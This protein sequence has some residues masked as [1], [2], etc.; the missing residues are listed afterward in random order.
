MIRHGDHI[1]NEGDQVRIVK[2]GAE[3]SSTVSY[4]VGPTGRG[5]RE[6]RVP[7]PVGTV[8]TYSGRGSTTYSSWGKVPFFSWLDEFG[9]HHYG[10]LPE[11]SLDWRCPPITDTSFYEVVQ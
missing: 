1:I 9:I 4:P 2:P 7:V 8:L 6:V 3:L 5:Y 10:R 11:I